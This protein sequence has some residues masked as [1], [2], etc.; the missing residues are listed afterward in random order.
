MQTGDGLVRVL[1][2]DHDALA[3][4]ALRPALSDAGLS[5]VGQAGDAAQAINL[6]TRCLPDVVVMDAGLPP[7]GGLSAMRELRT[8]APG[9]RVVLLAASGEDEAGLEALTNGAAGYLSRD[10]DL[11]S[12]ARA[13]ARVMVGEAAVSR[14]MVM[15]MVERLQE[16]SNGHA[17]L[18]PIRSS[19]TTR[20]WEVLDLLRSGL[21]TADMARELVLST[22]TVHT[23]VRNIMR[24]LRA[25]SR[26]EA[27][28]IAEQARMNGAL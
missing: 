25:H 5:V 26:A 24:K 9:A 11:P 22:D 13:V 2:A 12:L 28:E 7:T 15:R 8:A 4:N 14:A 16:R 10:T 21:S 17:G 1:I 3:R 27:V 20:E 6:A 18:R 23:H 19:L